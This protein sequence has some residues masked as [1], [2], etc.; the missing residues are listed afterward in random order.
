M[1][2][3]RIEASFRSQHLLIPRPIER[4]GAGL[5]AI[6][7]IGV[8]Y[9]PKSWQRWT[10]GTVGVLTGGATGLIYTVRVILTACAAQ[11]NKVTARENEQRRETSL[12]T[13]CACL[14]P[15]QNQA[16]FR[17]LFQ[18][19]ATLP[20][21]DRKIKEWQVGLKNL[22]ESWRSRIE[23][24]KALASLFPADQWDPRLICELPT[25]KFKG[26][27]ENLKRFVREFKWTSSEPLHFNKMVPQDWWN[28]RSFIER[29]VKTF[30]PQFQIFPQFSEHIFYGQANPYFNDAEAPFGLFGLID[31][32][33]IE[34]RQPEH[35]N[36][37]LGDKLRQDMAFLFSYLQAFPEDQQLP[38]NFSDA[39]G[40]N[41]ENSREF[42]DQ[43]L[44]AFPEA[45]IQNKDHFCDFAALH[46]ATWIQ[47]NQDPEY[48]LP[49][50]VTVDQMINCVGRHYV[51]RLLKIDDE[52]SL[53]A[54]RRWALL[55]GRLSKEGEIRN[56]PKYQNVFSQLKAD[57]E[58]VIAITEAGFKQMEWNSLLCQILGHCTTKEALASMARSS[59]ETNEIL[60]RNLEATQRHLKS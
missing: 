45:V 57:S 42:W 34:F 36:R 13:A 25:D 14:A 16:E 35:F 48:P 27:E 12:N 9:A 4:W 3:S 47:N 39:I 37:L 56:N 19:L 51:D 28:D 53:L 23:T 18:S 5:T 22:N 24:F 41:L 7:L 11:A 30:P 54:V 44:S 55:N 10:S 40:K 15:D 52:A 43:W 38:V 58:E 49:P 20:K 31:L 6:G 26:S 29:W 21:L 1:S 59:K 46:L 33:P 60:K 50:N 32:F 2:D 8:L 17:E